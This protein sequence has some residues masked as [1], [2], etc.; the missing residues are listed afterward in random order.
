MSQYAEV[1][2]KTAGPGDER[3]TAL[4]IIKNEGL[5][6]QMKDKVSFETSKSISY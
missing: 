4:Q 5:E 3:P 2:R 1:H 6:G